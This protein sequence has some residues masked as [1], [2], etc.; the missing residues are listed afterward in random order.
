M[1]SSRLSAIPYYECL[2]A[3]ISTEYDCRVKIIDHKDIVS[4]AEEGNHNG[5]QEF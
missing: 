5:C 3:S 1:E 2:R 4:L